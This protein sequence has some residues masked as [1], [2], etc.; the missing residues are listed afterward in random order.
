[1]NRDK[2]RVLYF[3]T[4]R[5]KGSILNISV[6]SKNSDRIKDFYNTMEREANTSIDGEIIYGSSY[7]TLKIF[8]DEDIKKYENTLMSF[9]TSIKK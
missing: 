4:P 2:N 3:I 5:E 1:V 8:L 6:D 7:T 9:V